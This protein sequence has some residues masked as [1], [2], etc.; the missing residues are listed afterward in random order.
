MNRKKR[1]DR[2]HVIYCITNTVT[3]EQYIGLTG[4]NST[5]KRALHV[6]IRKHI[7]RAMV[8]TKSWGLC[9]NIRKYGASA[10]TYGLVEVVRGKAQ[11]HVRETE[12]IKTFNPVL[13]TFK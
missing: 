3:G 1:T 2:N 12:L 13:N 6:R 5:V 4:V 9:E 10:F 7:Q 8:E 11:A